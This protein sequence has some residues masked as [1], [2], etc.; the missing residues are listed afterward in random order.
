MSYSRQLLPHISQ[1]LLEKAIQIL[2][3]KDE[4]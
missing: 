2:E 4:A 3:H 1:P